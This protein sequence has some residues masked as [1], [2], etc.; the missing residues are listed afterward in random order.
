MAKVTVIGSG[1]VGLCT[2]W[3]LRQAGA[4]VTVLTAAKSDATSGCSFGNAGLVVPS[5]FMP[6][7]APGVIRQGLKWMLN[8]KSPLYIRPRLDRD[9]I[10]WMWHFNASANVQN[11]ERAK[12]LLV[13]LNTASHGLFEELQQ[14]GDVGF[15]FEKRGLM[16][17]YKTAKYQDE[18]EALGEHA[19]ALGLPV[20]VLDAS[21]VAEKE[22]GLDPNVLGAVHYNCDAQIKPGAFMASMERRL[23]RAGVD[24]RFD[25]SITSMD[26]QSGAVSRIHTNQGTFDA[27]EVVI[28]AGIWSSAL[29]KNLG[30]SIPM[31]AGKGYSV[32]LENPPENLQ[33]PAI[34]CEAKIAMTP[35]GRD[36]R[37]A[38]TMELSG[39]NRTIST[40]RVE[41]IREQVPTYF[42]RFSPT[43]YGDAQPWVGLRPV[44]PD[45]L[46]YIGRASGWKNLHLN[47]GHAMMGISLAPISG[48]LMAQTITGQSP[49]VSLTHLQPDRFAR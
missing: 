33:H 11:V 8:P 47:T 31:Q 45:G 18:E 12:H 28:C 27:D 34:L 24:I 5:H 46:P 14:E 19:K 2:A 3:Y 9:L 23:A 21:Q 17:L 49:S 22:P 40:K 26:H 16:M 41:S 48:H 35:M 37:V 20:D 29:A 15:G 6:L 44:T 25:T 38:G 4:E 30:I 42:N 13:D 43:W 10:Q 32:T 1:A 39:T 36:L 7:A